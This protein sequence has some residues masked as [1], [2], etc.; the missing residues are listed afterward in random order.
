MHSWIDASTVQRIDRATLQHGRVHA[1][2]GEL[3]QLAVLF[4]PPYLRDLYRALAPRSPSEA[5]RRAVNIKLGW[6]DKI[7]LA[8]T[9]RFKERVE[10]GD[11][12]VFAIDQLAAPDGRPLGPARARGV[13]AQAK[14]VRAVE[15]MRR[16]LVPG[17]PVRNSTA[18]ELILLSD[19]PRF[20]LYKASRSDTPLVS[21]VD[22][23]STAVG[24]LPY[25]WYIAAPCD[26][27]SRLGNPPHPWASWWM[28][29]PPI[30]GDA[31]DTSFGSFL[32]AFL[33][34]TPVATSVGPL[35]VGAPFACP[36][37]PPAPVGGGW[38][39]LCAELLKLLE[40]GPAPQHIFGQSKTRIAS[41]RPVLNGF[42][43]GGAGAMHLLPQFAWPDGPTWRRAIFDRTG[44]EW[45]RRRSDE[46]PELGRGMPVLV[47]HTTQIDG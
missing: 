47:I 30:R 29:G 15:R 26:P 36:T 5:R 12:A 6:I 16:P 45:R 17:A 43:S 41:L 1:D 42:L 18:R 25:G 31:L 11:L 9:A 20:D 23:R 4:R 33:R 40:E 28:A 35:P 14:V 21:G 44:S 46:T 19:W 27:K 7:P 24:P 8:E 37:Y 22:L 32:G 10:L 38:D 2:L 34:G 39:R 3:E 13:L